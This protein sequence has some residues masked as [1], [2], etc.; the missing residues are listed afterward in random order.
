MLALNEKVGVVKN[1]VFRLD[2]CESFQL[3]SSHGTARTTV[4]RAVA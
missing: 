3:E 2:D 1:L 4:E